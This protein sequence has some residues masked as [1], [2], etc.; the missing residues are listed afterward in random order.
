MTL[1]FYLSTALE[2][3][4]FQPLAT[5][6]TVSAAAA[7]TT[8]TIM[9]NFCDTI[10]R[11]LLLFYSDSSVAPS[12]AVRVGNRR[13]TRSNRKSNGFDSSRLNSVTDKAKIYRLCH[14]NIDALVGLK[15][16]FIMMTNG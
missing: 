2:S 11:Y 16:M 15:R 14:A 3:M 10:Y 1:K 12:V 5:A 8:S 9:A 7:S 13:L 4:Y 6:T